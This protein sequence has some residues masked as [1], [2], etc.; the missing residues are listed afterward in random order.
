MVNF[1][2]ENI[3]FLLFAVLFPSSQGAPSPNNSELV[4]N[5]PQINNFTAVNQN[6]LAPCFLDVNITRTSGLFQRHNGTFFILLCR[7]D[8]DAID[9]A[10]FLWDFSRS[11][12]DYRISIVDDNI[13]IPNA[14]ILAFTYCTVT[15]FPYSSHSS[16]QPR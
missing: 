6:I 14:D 16:R 7:K 2:C 4:L 13:T 12:S 3:I 5:M 8:Y 9:Y 1:R 15:S 11:P 10:L